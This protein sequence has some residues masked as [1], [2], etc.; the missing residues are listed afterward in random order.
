M[1]EKLTI[2]PVPLRGRTVLVTGA[3]RRAGIGFAT[4]CRAAAAGANVFVHH[5]SPHDV[6]QPWGADDVTAVVAG[7]R[8]HLTPGARLAEVSLDLSDPAAPGQLV[9]AAVAE[10]GRVHG[11]VCNQA[12][13]GSDGPLASITAAELD[14]HWAV[15]TRASL[16]LAQAFAAQHPAG[17]AGAI[18]LL[19]S[20]QGLGPLPGEVAYGTAKAALAGITLTL[21]DELAD[22]GI[23]VNCV[24]PGPVDTGYVTPEMLAATAH[25][26]PA[27][28]W[29]E[30]DDAA[31]LLTWLLTDDARWITGQVL[32]SE[33]GF[34][35]WR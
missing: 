24:N 17:Q 30:P 28:R 4:A 11:L 14:R 8:S 34:A 31:R 29:G 3:S 2:D 10:F 32:N 9:A 23:R 7:I 1:P 15:N 6:E 27:G 22:V 16:L 5:F 13:S 25:M 21:A 19:T 35:R 26:F 18:V 33:G 12:L 20:G